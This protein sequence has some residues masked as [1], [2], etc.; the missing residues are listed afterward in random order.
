VIRFA[1]YDQFSREIWLPC[2][3]FSVEPLAHLDLLCGALRAYTGITPDPSYRGVIANYLKTT[4]KNYSS[5]EAFEISEPRWVHSFQG[6]NWLTCVG[7]VDRDRRRT[8]VLVLNGTN[9]VD[10]HYA[11]QTDDCGAQTYSVFEQMGGGGLEPLH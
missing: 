5:Y 3:C 4:F 11:V 1:N 2:T 7:F 10:A 9:I 8:Y 6:W